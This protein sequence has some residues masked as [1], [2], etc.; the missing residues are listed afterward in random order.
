M[1]DIA[2]RRARLA[3]NFVTVSEGID[4]FFVC[5]V[6]RLDYGTRISHYCRAFLLSGDVTVRSQ[7]STRIPAIAIIHNRACIY[8]HSRKAALCAAANSDKRLSGQDKQRTFT[9]YFKP[10]VYFGFDDA[11]III[12]QPIH[13]EFLA[14]APEDDKRNLG[15]TDRDQINVNDDY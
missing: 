11:A 14:K 1:R 9:S 7:L 8:A 5:T 4:F 10:L 3:R 15:C 2:T 12:T 6:L 13:A